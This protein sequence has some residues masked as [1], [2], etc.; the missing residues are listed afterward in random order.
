MSFSLSVCIPAYNRAEFMVPLLDS[1]R[2][3]QEFIYEV[4]VCEDLSPERDL[5]SSIIRDYRLSYPSFPLRYIENEKNLGYDANL[6]RLLES[7]SGD[8]C[9]FMGNDD[10]LLA[11]ALKRIHDVLNTNENIGVISR[12]YNWFSGSADNVIDTVRHLPSDKLFEAGTNAISFFFRRV[13]VLSGLVFKR[14]EAIELS[15]DRYDGHLYY[16]MYL[17]ATLLKKMRGFYIS[18]VQTSSRDGIVPDFGNA[19]AE[20]KNF[21]PG[22]YVY[23]ARVYMVRGLLNI[24]KDCDTDGELFNAVKN[25]ICNYFYPYIRDQLSLPFTHY[26]KMVRMFMDIGLSDKYMFWCYITIGY[27]LKKRGFDYA[28]KCVRN[29][30]GHTP[31]FGF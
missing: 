20:K 4:V 31:R 11:G 12:A 2:M 29:A 1:L 13:G 28:I 16:Q 25:D 24:A 9:L 17:T 26:I 3:Q 14:S 10:I 19:D 15:T 27:V 18:S 30:L 5:I 8:Y 22:E 7:S 23:S 6:R 21:K